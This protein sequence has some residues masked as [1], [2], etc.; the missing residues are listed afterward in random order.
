MN[1]S[2]CVLITVGEHVWKNVAQ[3][4]S[5]RTTEYNWIVNRPK[6]LKESEVE[7]FV[8][9]GSRV[10]FS[11]TSLR[12]YLKRLKRKNRKECFGISKAVKTKS[13]LRKLVESTKTHYWDDSF[14]GNEL[15]EY[16]KAGISELGKKLKVT[17]QE[18]ELQ[19]DTEGVSVKMDVG[20]ESQSN[21]PQQS[22]PQQSDPQPLKE[23]TEVT[24]QRNE[25]KIAVG[26]PKLTRVSGGLILKLL[27][28]TTSNV[29]GIS[30]NVTGVSDELKRLS[31]GF[32]TEMI[33][34]NSKMD[35]FAEQLYHKLYDPMFDGDCKCEKCVT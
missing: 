20:S 6:D 10:V 1:V 19:T 14:V 28:R 21:T 3:Y 7:V 9:W 15:M 8:W 22:D 18:N 34:V 5:K 26:Q 33:K 27:S 25:P 35:K 12:S 11:A 31:E 29:I 16:L 24:K 2:Q 4:L 13:V 23:K 17:G 30:K 32:R